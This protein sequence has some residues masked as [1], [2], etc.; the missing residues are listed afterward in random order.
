MF[1]SSNTFGRGVSRAK[2]LVAAMAL[3]CAALAPAAFGS[4][5]RSKPAATSAGSTATQASKKLSVGL[6]EFSGADVSSEEIMNG[7]EAYAHKQGWAID[8]VDSQGSP[9][10]AISTIENLVTKKVDLIVTTVYAPKQLA[11]GILQAKAAGIP[12][13]SLDGG[14]GTGIQYFSD[15]GTVPGKQMAALM[16]KD[17]G[18]HGDL[19]SFTYPDGL[20]C[21]GRDQGLAQATAHAHF[22]SVTSVVAA[23][24]GT[25]PAAETVTQ[26]WLLKHPATGQK[27]AIFAC[28]D[29]PA[30]GAVAALKAAGRKKGQVLVYGI[31]AEGPAL[32][33]V[34]SGW[35]RA[36]E[37]IGPYG[38]GVAAAKAAPKVVADGVNAKP[39]VAPV[40]TEVVTKQNLAAFLKTNPG[41]MG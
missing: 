32:Q 20:P 3:L 15:S 29:D 41:A 11:G 1:G 9:N 18:G 16:M 38:T 8:R 14:E 40:P 2:I 26:A 4:S 6:V 36:T 12:V 23:V 22:S 13:M 27:Q 25:V 39:I 24:P 10:N 7:F 37:F 31:N 17:T 19:L 34:K 5:T 35:M 33:A 28:W 30:L 21:A